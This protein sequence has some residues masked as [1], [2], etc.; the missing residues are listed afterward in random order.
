MSGGLP[1]DHLVLPPTPFEATEE[2]RARVDEL[3]QIFTASFVDR[4]EAAPREVL[5]DQRLLRYVRFIERPEEEMHAMIQLRRALD[6]DAVYDRVRAGDAFPSEPE[7]ADAWEHNLFGARVRDYQGRPVF[8][9]TIGGLTTTR[10]LFVRVQM[11][12][13]RSYLH[14]CL[15]QL[16]QRVTDSSE[17]ERLL[18]SW[19][20]VLDLTGF[21]LWQAA[22]S[23]ASRSFFKQLGD[24]VN[25]LAVPYQIARVLLVN[26]PPQWQLIWKAAK[27]ILPPKVQRKVHMCSSPADLVGFI[28]IDQLPVRYG[29][30]CPDESTFVQV[31]RAFAPAAA[32][33]LSP[34]TQTPR[35][36]QPASPLGAA[37]GKKPATAARRPA[38]PP[39]HRRTH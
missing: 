32:E 6:M 1:L 12:Q 7:M 11:E 29:G 8:I 34:T 23:E 30:D 26:A 4:S 35:F 13:V 15:E 37:R 14:H 5:S 19:T 31:R 28:S 22:G 24:E 17:Q 27:L 3:R 16:N 2:E 21:S 20:Y 9:A 38:S 18:L 33:P 10:Q 36:G 39:A 25:R